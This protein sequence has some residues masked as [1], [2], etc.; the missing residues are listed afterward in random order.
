MNRSILVLA[1]ASFVA[2]PAFAAEDHSAHAMHGM[3]SMGASAPAASNAALSEG[4]VK[5]VDKAAGTVTLSHGPLKNLGMGPM[6]MSFAVADAA[7]LGKLKVGDKV[8]FL[9]E[10]KD[11]ALTASRIELA[12]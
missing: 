7:T 2:A 5:K 9:A 3:S 11:G 8:R 4:I 1:L 12:K 6:T 10:D